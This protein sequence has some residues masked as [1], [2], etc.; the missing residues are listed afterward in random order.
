MGLMDV[1]NGMQNGPRGASEPGKGGMSPLT[2]ALI[3]LLGYKAI[4]KL[5]EGHASAPQPAPAPLPGPAGNA[6]GGL[7][8]GLGGGLGG[9]LP[10][11]LG[12][13]LAGGAAGSILSGGLGD[14]LKHFQDGGHADTVNS[15]VGNGANQ[16]I[17][18]NAL[19]SILGNERIQAALQQSGLSKDDLLKGLSQFL[20]DAVNHMTPDGRL[21]TDQEFSQRL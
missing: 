8:G 4:N 18:P 10:G 19:E 16:P 11:G 3:A 5:R 2:M 13:L 20:P 14:L 9:L 6:G 7:A 21:P 1:L 17:A 12:G 15:W